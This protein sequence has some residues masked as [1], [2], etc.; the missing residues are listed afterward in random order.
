MARYRLTKRAQ[1]IHLDTLR[2]AGWT[3]AD[4]IDHG[5]L[6]QVPDHAVLASQHMAALRNVAMSG[7]VGAETR[8]RLLEILKHLQLSGAVLD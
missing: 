4:L 7:G 5:I 3:T 1:S 2:A 6:E 8:Q